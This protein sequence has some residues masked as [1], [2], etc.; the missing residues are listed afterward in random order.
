[1]LLPV[2]TSI[3]ILLR[4]DNVAKKDKK[5]RDIR[6]DV[7][8][9]KGCLPAFIT[10]VPSF[11]AGVVVGVV[12]GLPALGWLLKAITAVIDLLGWLGDFLD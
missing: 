2:F 1:M 8:T 3:V 7:K 11:L 4:G 5:Q 10:S 9:A 6:L 12:C